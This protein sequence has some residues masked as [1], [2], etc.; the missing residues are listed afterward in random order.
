MIEDVVDSE[1][2]LSKAADKKNE[3][4]RAVFGLGINIT[5]IYSHRQ[6]YKYIYFLNTDI[7]T[8]L[9][10]LMLVLTIFYDNI[11]SLTI[12]KSIAH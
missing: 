9:D 7:T 8:L 10:T 2:A 4:A 1:P 11:T 6:L 5:L 3:E 12:Q